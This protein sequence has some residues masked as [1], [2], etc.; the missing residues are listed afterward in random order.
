MSLVH[1]AGAEMA[2]IVLGTAPV[3]NSAIVANYV[4]YG[5]I[6]DIFDPHS[7]ACT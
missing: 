2:G 5:L 3:K 7:V 1:G 6:T 4:C